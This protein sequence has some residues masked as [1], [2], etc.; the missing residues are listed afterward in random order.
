MATPP[1]DKNHTDDFTKVFLSELA[2]IKLR[3]GI[4]QLSK[5][6]IDAE[7]TRIHKRLEKQ[8]D[9]EKPEKADAP[10]EKEPPECEKNGDQD[11][12]GKYSVLPSTTACLMGLALS[13]GGIRSAT[14]NL[15]LLQALCNNGMFW[16]LW[17]RI[18]ILNG[19]T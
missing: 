19:Y 1:V 14:F 9:S 16:I 4:S 11:R 17:M 10:A 3:K 5:D 18:F 15:G 6:K 8:G 2:D 13:G 7:I 12:F